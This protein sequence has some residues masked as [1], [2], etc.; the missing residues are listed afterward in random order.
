[1]TTPAGRGEDAT[2]RLRA[3]VN[4][5]GDAQ[6]Y[7]AGENQYISITQEAPAPAPV[8]ALRTLPRDVAS[9]TGRQ[10][11]VDQILTGA[12]PSR[13]VAIHTIDGMPGAGK[14]ALAVHAARQLT[15]QYP[16][17]QLFVRLN[18][19]TPGHRPVDPADALAALLLSLG[20][21][22]RSIPDGLEARAGLWRD[23]LTGRRVLLVLDDAVD[24]AQVEPLLPGSEGCLVLVTSRHRLTAL[25]GAAPLPL[26]ILP[27]QDASLL[28]TRLAHRKPT[29]VS[30]SEALRRIV[31][32]CGFL[33]LA[34]A[35]LA[36]R[37]AHH[38]HWNLTDYA[39]E[40]AA[41]QD[42]LGELAA[43]DRAVEA[44][45][46]M[47]YR[48]LP[49]DRQRLFRCLGLHFGPDTDAYATAA[50]GDIPLTSARRELEALYLDHLIDSPATGRYRLHD[51]IRTYARTLTDTHDPADE[52][53]QATQRLMDYYQHTAETADPH[54]TDTPRPAPRPVGTSPA[55]VPSLT[56]HQ[57]ALTWMRVERG[58]LTACIHHATA[59]AQHSR[60]IRLTAALAAFLRL[61]GPWD[62]AIAL[63]QSAATSAR[64]T[65]DRLAQAAALRE[66]GEVRY[67][68]GNLPVTADLLN[69]ALGLSRALGD[70]LGEA[71][72][73]WTLGRVRYLTGDYPAATA[74]LQQALDLY[75]ALGDR[76][77]EAGALRGLGH[78]RYATGDYPAA[79]DLLKRALDLYRILGDRHGEA[80]ALWE[81][82]QVQY[83]T[84]DYPAASLAQRALDLYRSLGNRL[85]E[86]GALWTL[87][88]VR[89]L[90]GDHPA[91]ADL[92]QQALELSR[93]L[94]DRHCEANALQDLGRLQTATGDYPAAADRLRRSLTLFRELGDVQGEAEVLNSTGALLAASATPDEALAVYRQ[95]LRLARQVHSAL[96]EARALEGTARCYARIGSHSTALATLR[97]AVA[98]YQRLGAAEASAAAEYL[99]TL[100]AHTPTDP[101][102]QNST[103]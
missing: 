102:A 78:V 9:F 88:R 98:D 22:P 61:Q 35:L 103:G 15:D 39:E 42:R 68:T 2:A 91:A 100:E 36:G 51:L 41:A 37:F 62:E 92:L 3:D 18:A 97:R 25:D 71:G 47:S 23:R 81:L 79:A 77:G 67:M 17:G 87:G 89:Y 69:Q 74:L 4:A 48:A 75:R 32:L 99:A 5:H 59:I 93:T 38:S 64:L 21:D 10:V 13:V 90:T 50:L 28:F 85:G 33:P 66:L 52:R 94:G 27:A 82:G 72:A 57:Q 1:M 56:S 20:I 16:D 46:D 60:A 19:H 40:L 58:N 31:E 8:T 83:A 54:L 34:I 86:A 55:A 96:D 73:R 95:A 84:G 30:E 65:G 14:T 70:R 44:A 45:F 29:T 26:G 101:Q 80:N 6:V 49:H 53:E 7:V 76:L 24:H 63:H 11:E 12:R 43:G